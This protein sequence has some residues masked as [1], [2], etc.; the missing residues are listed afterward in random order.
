MPRM[1]ERYGP[2]FAQAVSEIAAQA[3]GA[4]LFHCRLGKDRTGALSAVLL[5]LAGVADYDVIEDYLATT[6]EE[7]KVRSLL[8]ANGDGDPP[9]EP[10]MAR[11]P[12][13]A[14]SM[15]AMLASLDGE[16]GGARA[17]LEGHG[18]APTGLDTLVESMLAA[19]ASETAVAGS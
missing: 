9:R 2:F 15:V 18:V 6:A 8:A 3:E 19:A 7:S 4:A 11:E 13:I 10:R 16:H 17:Y 5:K 1:L 12:A 14:E